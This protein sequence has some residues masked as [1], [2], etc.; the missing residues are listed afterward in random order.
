MYPHIYVCMYVFLLQ[1]QK[2]LAS[3]FP[4][5]KNPQR[6]N[7]FELHFEKEKKEREKIGSW[8][9]VGG[10]LR[11][12]EGKLRK[13]A[14]GT[15]FQKLPYGFLPAASYLLCIPTPPGENPGWTCPPS[16]PHSPSLQM[17][18]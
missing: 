14:K 13:E 18:P 2:Q 3:S 6:L 12:G 11:R 16:L 5:Q 15:E 10:R 17:Y 1:L 4:P 7:F 8:F 9:W